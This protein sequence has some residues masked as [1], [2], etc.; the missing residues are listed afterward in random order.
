MGME[1]NDLLREQAKKLRQI[2]DHLYTIKETDLLSNQELIDINTELNSITAELNSIEALLTTNNSLTT[3]TN[4]L[5]TSTNTKIDTTNSKIDSTNSKIDSTNLKIDSTNSKLDLT[6]TKLDTANTKLTDV[7]SATS[8]S[9]GYNGSRVL[10]GTSAVTGQFRGFVVNDDAVV[11]ACLDKDGNSLMTSMGF[12]GVT[13]LQGPF[14]SVSE[15]NWISS[16][17]LTSGSIVLYNK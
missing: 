4:S 1:N 2:A 5:V 10:S 11:S 9:A 12:T 17:T 3:T 15:T 14:H 6:N 16:I 13:L 8:F 7:D